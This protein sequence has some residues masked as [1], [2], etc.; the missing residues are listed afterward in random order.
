M[1]FPW[2]NVRTTVI[3][4]TSAALLTAGSLG[5]APSAIAAATATVKT[6]TQRMSDANLGSQQ[7]G[8]YNPGDQLTLVCSKRGQPVK[9]FFSFNIPNGGW[10][11]LWYKTSDGNFVADVDIETGTLN[12]VAGSDCGAGGTPPPPP[13][14]AEVRLGGI[15]LDQACKA[16]WGELA[17]EAW[18]KTNDAYGWQCRHM[19]TVSYGG[20]IAPYYTNIGGLDMN[21]ACA[22]QYAQY[23]KPDAYARLVENHAQG[24]ACFRKG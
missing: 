24:W 23:G 22:D 2:A 19:E 13:Q 20:L 10:D 21:R 6:Q 11:N 3:S 4:V 12:D 15:N 5:V 9:G 16:Q 7:N 18:L 14:P 17:T 8:W 1:A